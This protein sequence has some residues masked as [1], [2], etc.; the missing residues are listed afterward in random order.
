MNKRLKARII[1][2]YGIQVDYAMALKADE[3]DVSRVIRGRRALSP[4]AYKSE[5]WEKIIWITLQKNLAI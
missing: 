2:V 4:D 1:E 3:S 5:V